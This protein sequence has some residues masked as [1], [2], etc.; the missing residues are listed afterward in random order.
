MVNEFVF[1]A[2]V[3]QAEHRLFP[4]RDDAVPEA[5]VVFDVPRRFVGCVE[6]HEELFGIPGEEGGEV[7]GDLEGEERLV[8]SRRGHGVQ[9][10]DACEGHVHDGIG[11]VEDV[12]E[13]RHCTE[14]S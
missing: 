5:D 7:G 2:H 13:S 6:P 9:A 10:F 8:V 1:V 11:R 4:G 12:R 14:G 3:R